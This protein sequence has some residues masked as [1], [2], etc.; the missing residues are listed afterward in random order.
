MMR[1]GGHVAQRFHA[2]FIPRTSLLL[3][4]DV[5]VRH[6]EQP[7]LR[8]LDLLAGGTAEE[9]TEERLLQRI[10]GGLPVVCQRAGVTQYTAGL[11]RVKVD[12]FL[13]NSRRERAAGTAIHR[14]RYYC[15]AWRSK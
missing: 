10:M 15:G 4:Q 2:D 6:P 5:V 3:I 7:T 14:S 8:G 9:E 12:D 11:P 1:R 13:L